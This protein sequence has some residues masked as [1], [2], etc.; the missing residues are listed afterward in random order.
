MREAGVSPN[1]AQAGSYFP[2]GQMKQ[3][4]YGNGFTY[5][6]TQTARQQTLRAF[7]RHDATSTFATDFTY[8][9]DANGLITSITDGVVS[10]E[11]RTFGYD[12]LNRLIDA[13]GPWGDADYTYDQ[14]NNLLSKVFTDGGTVRTVNMLYNGSNRLYRYSDTDTTGGANK[15]ISYDARGN[16]INNSRQAFTYDRANQPTAANNNGV[17]ASFAY[18]GNYKRVKQTVNGETIYTVY[19]QSGAILLRDNVTTGEVTDY[20]RL[21]GMTVAELKNG[22]REYLMPDHLGTPVVG[23]DAS[24][25]ILWRDSRTPF[26]ESMAA[27]SG[28]ADR[29]GYTGH[30]EDTDLKLTYMQA[31][32]YD[33]VLG[34]FMSNDPVGFIEGGISYHNRFSYTA[35]N[36]VN[37][38]DSDGEKVTPI[39]DPG[40]V[41]RIEASLDKIAAADPELGRRLEVLRKSELEHKIQLP[42]RIDG[43]QRAENITDAISGFDKETKTFTTEFPSGTNGERAPTTTFFNPDFS[44]AASSPEAILAHELLG[45]GYEKDQGIHTKSASDDSDNILPS[46]AR[47]Q[48]IER[49]YQDAVGEPHAVREEP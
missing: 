15:N 20:I 13:T 33:P 11:S 8:A 6:T 24:R 19:G 34:R 30:I 28:R 39:G 21:G 10:G 14:N 49:I 32:Y 38:I 42:D 26:G 35:N 37:A 3:L 36:P 41:A 4:V 9:Y 5:R 29:V 45:H 2:N 27:I 18:D 16:V 7:I 44:E 43:D 25:N 46:E 1:A 22:V 47:A 31:R 40:Y 23:T 48:E 17:T 12:G